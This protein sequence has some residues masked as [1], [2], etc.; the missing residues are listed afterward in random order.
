MKSEMYEQSPSTHMLAVVSLILSILGLVPLLPVV[1]SIGG[2]ISGRIAR[3]E[4][5]ENPELYQGEGIARAG[6]VLGWVGVGL[7]ITIGLA[8]LAALLFFVPIRS[9]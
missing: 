9:G 3:R 7:A 1:G 2:I 6:I 8:I 5:W 4:I